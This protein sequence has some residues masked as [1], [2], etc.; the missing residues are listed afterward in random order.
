MCIVR[1][2]SERGV[3][4]RLFHDPPKGSPITVSLT[5]SSEFE[6][7]QVWHERDDAGFEFAHLVELSRFAAEETAYQK[8]GLRLAL[9]FPIT[10]TAMGTPQDGFVENLSQ[11][12]ACFSCEGEYALAQSLSV[13]CPEEEIHLGGVHAKVRW[14]RGGE[15]GV[16]FEN[17]LSLEEFARL[18]ARL[19]CPALLSD[20]P[21]KWPA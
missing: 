10:I 7:K 11:R 6:V 3:R 13:E 12:G 4:L 5:G 17:T 1:D 14:R 15:Y 9:Q 8:R 21:S 16:V 19:Q 20:R 18:A 2:V